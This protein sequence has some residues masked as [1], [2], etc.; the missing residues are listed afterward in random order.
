M[1][2]VSKNTVYNWVLRYKAIILS[3]NSL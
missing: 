2:G 1:L 3:R